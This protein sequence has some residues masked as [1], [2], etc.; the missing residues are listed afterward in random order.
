MSASI[1]WRRN[2]NCDWT[3]VMTAPQQMDA[4]V[5]LEIRQLLHRT[6]EDCV[7]SHSNARRRWLHRQKQVLHLVECGEQHSDQPRSRIARN[8]VALAFGSLQ[9]D[10]ICH[11]ILGDHLSD[12]SGLSGSTQCDRNQHLSCSEVKGLGRALYPV[13]TQ[14]ENIPAKRSAPGFWTTA[15][16]EVSFPTNDRGS[17]PWMRGLL[18]HRHQPHEAA[19]SFSVNANIELPGDWC[20]RLLGIHGCCAQCC[21]A[22]HTM[23]T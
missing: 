12:Q 22:V 7:W 14:H 20:G 23:F 13:T 6:I 10:S 11:A 1:L 21:R 9:I 19:I 15:V 8:A 5:P 3:A 16:S 4:Q 2:V 18:F 17:A